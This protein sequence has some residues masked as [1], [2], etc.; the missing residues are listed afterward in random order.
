MA[1]LSSV[2]GATIA[3][4]LKCQKLIDEEKSPFTNKESGDGN[5]MN[6]ADSPY[7]DTSMDDYLTSPE[8]G[9]RGPYGSVDHMQVKSGCCRIYELY[10][11]VGVHLDICLDENQETQTVDFRES[12]G[13]D[14]DAHTWA[15]EI[16]SWKCARDMRVRWCY[17]QKGEDCDKTV[18]SE[19]GHN[20]SGNMK[21]GANDQIQSLVLTRVEEDEAFATLFSEPNCEGFS[22][23]VGVPE[24]ASLAKAWRKYDSSFSPYIGEGK[25]ASVMIGGNVELGLYCNEQFENDYFVVHQPGVIRCLNLAHVPFEKALMQGDY[26]IRAVKIRKAPINDSNLP[27]Q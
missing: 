4:N 2:K 26:G 18:Q 14:S 20:R 9:K 24:E 27:L 1:E 10:N 13:D 16:S 5:F 12:F 23:I 19:S 7:V 21:V 3:T 25:V 6:A 8:C 15:N 17:N 11:F 22:T